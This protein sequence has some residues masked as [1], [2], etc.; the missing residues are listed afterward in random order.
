MSESA[1]VPGHAPARSLVS[2]VRRNDLF[3]R[4]AGDLENRL[5]TVTAP[6]GYGKTELLALIWRSARRR[7][8]C[9]I[10]IDLQK[11]W[12][13]TEVAQALASA[14]ATSPGELEAV[15]NAASAE[16]P[17][18]LIFDKA[19][20]TEDGAEAIDW[21][22]DQISAGVRIAVSGRRLPRLRL[23]RMRMRGLLAE[24]GPEDLAFDRG[25]MQQIL[26]QRL[27]PEVFERAAD[28]LAGWPALVQLAAQILARDTRVS[29]QKMVLDGTHPILRDF[30]VEE[31]MPELGDVERALMRASRDLLDF[32][33][34]IVLD[35][36]GRPHDLEN[37]AITERMPPLILANG[38]RAGWFRRHPV[39]GAA[40]EACL[41]ETAEERSIRLQ[42]ASRL[43]AA[44]GHLE[45][46]VLYA[47]MAGDYQ[48]AV[49]TIEA[50]GGADLFLRAGLL[51]LRG[52]MHA[53][54]HDVVRTTPSLRLCRAVL[55]A[56]SGLIQEA[57]STIRTM[58]DELGAGQIVG[59]R[60]L[61]ALLEHLSSL[62]D[63]YEDRRLDRP[64]TDRLEQM[65]ADTPAE[66][67]WRLGWIH[68]SLAIAY[69][70]S[71]DLDLAQ[72]HAQRALQCY[73][74]EGSVYPQIFM[75]VHLSFIG[76]QANRMDDAWTYGRDAE[77][78]IRS[79]QWADENLLAI[80]QVPL[81]ALCYV[82]GD[83]NGARDMLE[84]ALP[85]MAAG[86]G[87]VDFFAVGYVTLARAH[88][89]LNRSAAGLS[90][91]RDALAQGGG[92]AE[93]RGLP[94]LRTALALAEIELLTQAGQFDEA[95]SLARRL[96]DTETVEV[97]RTR[98]EWAEAQLAMAR[99]ALRTGAVA[100]AGSRLQAVT[101]WA[102]D[103]PE[104]QG[105]MLRVSLLEIER[106]CLGE[107]QRAALVWLEAAARS[108]AAGGQ[109]QQAHDET[110]LPNLVR[111]LVRRVGIGKLS[112]VAAELVTRIARGPATEGGLLSPRETEILRLLDEGLS[113]KMIA[114]RLD[115]SEATV[116]FHMKNLFAKLGV[117][118]RSLAVAVA[119]TNG[120]I[121][122]TDV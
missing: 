84:R 114:R 41:D 68:N 52:I 33:P 98:R 106:A 113:N 49:R 44:R 117:G 57:R 111:A 102:G 43:F 116:K 101:A 58:K 93:A 73:R 118:R 79:R 83:V 91:A 86:E 63:V 61:E 54:P 35:L 82:K 18:T 64:W 72:R 99:L 75:L 45:Q 70:R 23:S 60:R 42:H 87:W 37:L 94:R 8:Q 85:V 95:A 109:V 89:S 4:M 9:A 19:E 100:E 107:D 108:A 27:R 96:P 36:A 3:A 53:V 65:I 119:R 104:W 39:V 2:I 30:I 66:E 77:N 50:A 122:P 17:V 20:M 38:Q 105:V 47:S 7:G 34:E 24:Y 103:R 90:L 115:L 88:Y 51:V 40:L 31:V 11:G 67:T 28:T 16:A 5:V 78:L 92:V 25:E 121:K 55:L 26:G 62:F 110:G 97:W 13:R 120:L 32:T 46:A 80:A 6:A 76:L 10:W 69:T 48:L 81:A 59:D 74:D 1:A 14:L 29:T 71:V 112:P 15:L 21:L 56:K 12:G 22:L